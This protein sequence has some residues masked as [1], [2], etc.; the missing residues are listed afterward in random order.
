[1]ASRDVLAPRDANLDPFS[2]PGA[3]PR[4]HPPKG[5]G[6]AKV[7]T[8]SRRRNKAISAKNK[9]RDDAAKLAE[10]LDALAVATPEQPDAD[11]VPQTRSSPALA[12]DGGYDGP[13]DDSDSDCGGPGSVL[14]KATERR[15]F[16]TRGERLAKSARNPR[17]DDAA[18]EANLADARD[19]FARVDD[20]SLASESASPSVAVRASPKPADERQPPIIFRAPADDAADDAP[21]AA[22]DENDAHP[23]PTTPG[24]KRALTSEWLDAMPESFSP[25]PLE[26][27]AEDPEV[28]SAVA[29]ASRRSSA[30]DAASRGSRSSLAAARRVSAAAPHARG[31]R[32]PSLGGARLSRDGRLSTGM[33]RASLRA[34]MLPREVTTLDEL[35]EEDEENLSVDIEEEYVD[36]DEEAEAAETAAAGDEDD[37]VVLASPVA[38]G[39]ADAAA[40]ALAGTL[41]KATLEETS[42]D[43]PLARLLRECGQSERDVLP[44]REAT[45]GWTKDGVRKIGEGTYGEAFKGDGVVL[46]IVPMGGERLVNGEP[47]MGPGQIRAEAVVA[48]RLAQLRPR[49]DAP[50]EKNATEGFIDT[51]SVSVCCGP[52][53]PQLLEAWT[54]YD[55]KKKSENENPAGFDDDQLYVVFAC[56]DGGVDLEHVHLNSAAEA[57]STL[58]Q[59]TIALA[60][61]EEACAFEHRDLHWGNVLL[62]RCGVEETRVAR[63]NGVNVEYPTNGLEVSIIDF[64]LSRL[65]VGGGGSKKADVAFCDL[66]ADPELFRGPEGHCQ[67]ETYR[68]M[69]KATKGRWERRCPKTNALWLHYLADCLLTDKRYPATNAQKSEIKAFKKRTMGYASASEALWDELFVGRFKTGTSKA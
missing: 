17:R 55:E 41:E 49:E 35:E 63:L 1:M 22:A 59:I 19:F 52:Y 26:T 54:E 10:E 34:S 45:R 64:T 46:K 44:M 32:G 18:V 57:R 2:V 5:A 40:D 58:M 43:A 37:D 24:T 6:G 42:E 16:V 31:S 48:K 67:S 14:K 68:R 4:A 69:R 53:A 38:A 60:V 65:D 15:T 66:E 28:P 39:D 56:A 11:G 25:T 23:A 20:F 8:Y 50:L 27:L 7:I 3:V 30:F 13:F 12:R 51:L 33:E 62:R 9:E 61:A 36:S 29:D 47:Q 21:A